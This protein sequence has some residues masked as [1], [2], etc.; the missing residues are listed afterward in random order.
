MISSEI[1]LPS[2][3]L[4]LSNPIYKILQTMEIAI[5][6]AIP[7]NLTI[8]KT[9]RARKTPSVPAKTIVKHFNIKDKVILDFGC[10][11]SMDAQFFNET[12]AT[13]FRYDNYFLP[14][15]DLD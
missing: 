6:K 2:N 11:K 9:A 3:E 7:S 1:H 15:T 5:K 14:T 8:H 13:T 12:G 10:G 4:N